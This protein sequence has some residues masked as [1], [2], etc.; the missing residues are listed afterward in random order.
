LTMAVAD[1]NQ[2]GLP[3]IVVPNTADGTVSVLLGGAFELTVMQD[4][5]STTVTSSVNGSAYGQSVTFTATVTADAPGSGTP[6]GTVTFLDGSSTLGTGVLSGGVAM[7]TTSGLAVG[8]HAITISYGGDANFF[9]ST[10]GT[11]TQTVGQD[12]SS[13]AVTTSVNPATG[14]Q[15]VTFTAVVNAGSPGSGTPTGTVIFED[16]GVSIGCGSLSGG[17]A[18][19]TTSGLSV[20]THTITVAYQGDGNFS[21]SLSAALTQTVA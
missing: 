6:T 2:D 8:N 15:N 18:T 12:S 20:G 7:L 3:D 21:S 4:S 1:V 9:A 17:V 16:G 13:A 10:C 14:G 5:T 11:L 19:F